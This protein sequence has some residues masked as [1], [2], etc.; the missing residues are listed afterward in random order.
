M[1]LSEMTRLLENEE[2]LINDTATYSRNNAAWGTLHDYGN[3]V[4]GEAGIVVFGFEWE[5]CWWF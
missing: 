4:L 3:I 5:K 2:N 1:L